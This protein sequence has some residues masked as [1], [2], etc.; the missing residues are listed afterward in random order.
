MKLKEILQYQETGLEQK[1]KK[2]V[3]EA[4]SHIWKTSLAWAGPRVTMAVNILNTDL[5]W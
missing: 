3:K 1:C 5:A 2:E 4:S